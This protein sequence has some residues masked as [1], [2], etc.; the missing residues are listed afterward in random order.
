MNLNQAKKEIKVNFKNFKVDKI[1]VTGE[2]MDS[3]AFTVNDKY[4]F[5]FPK[6]KPSSNQLEREIKLLPKLQQRLDLPIPNFEYVGKQS[7][8]FYFVG[9]KK[10][11]G[12]FLEPKRYLELKKKDQNKFIETIATF[13]KQIH[14]FSIDKA[15]KCGVEVENAKE[16]CRCDMERCRK[17]I[18]P[19]LSKLEHVYVEK[20]FNK[21]L[22]NK[23]NFKYT[24][25]LLHSDLSY[26]HI[27]Y[28]QEN[29]TVAGIIDFGDIKIGDPAYELKFLLL[30]YGKEFIESLLKIYPFQSEQMLTRKMDFF[31]K[32]NNIS[33]ILVGIDRNDKKLI[34]YGLK[35]L[36]ENISRRV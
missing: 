25:A 5:R 4:I 28:N 11:H 12:S 1:E 30:D 15:L 18:F 33:D 32:S 14:S 34:K 8:G 21:Y 22:S 9:Y 31:I 10:I 6:F 27:I 19:M 23:E 35:C 26:E 3:K 36:R 24:P 17:E 29:K 16:K 13:F 2:G 7:N 20:I